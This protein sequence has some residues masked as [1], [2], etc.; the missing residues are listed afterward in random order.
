MKWI[1]VD[2]TTLIAYGVFDKQFDAVA[3]ANKFFTDY[4]ILPFN[5]VTV[6]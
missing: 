4:E 1:V 3:Y 6:D 2:N 5:I